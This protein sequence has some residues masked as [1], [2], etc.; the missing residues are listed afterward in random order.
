MRKAWDLLPAECADYGPVSSGLS[1]SI[2]GERGGGERG[3]SFILVTDMVVAGL[4]P[5]HQLQVEL[6][7]RSGAV[8]GLDYCQLYNCSQLY[9]VS[10][11]DTK[12]GENHNHYEV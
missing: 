4:P 8:T 12:L 11:R 10:S 2:T 7:G 3:E 1:H 9:S 5:T 6:G